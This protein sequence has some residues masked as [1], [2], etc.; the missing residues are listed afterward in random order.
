MIVNK[1]NLVRVWT[2]G[3]NVS[4]GIAMEFWGYVFQWKGKASTP[5]QRQ[6]RFR[7]VYL[8]LSNLSWD[9]EAECAIFNVYF[10]GSMNRR[11]KVSNHPGHRFFQALQGHVWKFGPGSDKRKNTDRPW[12]WV[13]VE[14]LNHPLAPFKGMHW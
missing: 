13:R 14:N 4:D 2:P 8:F 7:E 9:A 6:A 12:K 3:S 11:F 5:Q 10:W 1:L